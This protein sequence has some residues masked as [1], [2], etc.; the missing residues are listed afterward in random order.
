[1]FIDLEQSSSLGAKDLGC[2]SD[3]QLSTILHTISHVITHTLKGM[4][5]G[6]EESEKTSSLHQG[7]LSLTRAGDSGVRVSLRIWVY[8]ETQKGR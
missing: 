7:A 5:I 6:S 1:M 8:K 2:L 3:L 4:K